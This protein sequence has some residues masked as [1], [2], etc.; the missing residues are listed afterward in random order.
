MIASL[1]Q[2]PHK[3]EIRMKSNNLI[4]LSTKYNFLLILTAI[5]GAVFV[6]LSTRYGA[7][8]AGDSWDYIAAARN[9]IRGI[10]FIGYNNGDTFVLW[11][12]LYP[13]LLAIIG[14]IFRTD[15]FL[16]AGV[17][18][19]LIFGLIVYI[20]G[21]LT[22]RHLSSF[23]VFAFVGTLTLLFSIPLF[24]VSL[25]AWAEPVFILFVILSL[26]FAESY[27]AKN[28]ITSLILLSSSIALSCLT[29]YIGVSLILWGAVI[30]IIFR[31]DGLK[32]RIRH[33][34]IFILISSLPL[35]I[36]LI[37]N[38]AITST[39]F[40]PRVPSVSTL[41]QSLYLTSHTLLTWYVPARFA[42]SKL[43]LILLS[44]TS[45]VF[46]G[47]CIKDIFQRVRVAAKRTSPIVLFIV[48]YTAF[49]IISG[50]SGF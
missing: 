4:A 35:W 48:I 41:P 42:K 12:P 39:L 32:V 34:S 45:V 15:P 46:M 2:Q 14:V 31:Q 49:L 6:L 27:L 22:F 33:L 8:L 36:W 29:R 38:Y 3:G 21:L 23:P 26:I 13:A 18:N 1:G 17:V 19:A 44:A 5:L 9:L 37:R 43:M 40:G 16:I 10:G 24:A 50:A 20:G 28:D 25:M 47:L 7:G 30:I 11:P